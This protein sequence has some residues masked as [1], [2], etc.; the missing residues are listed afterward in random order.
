MSMGDVS[1]A[2]HEAIDE[3]ER[4]SNVWYS[5]PRLFGLEVHLNSGPLRGCSS[6]VFE[7]SAS[8]SPRPIKWI[9]IIMIIIL[10]G[11]LACIPDNLSGGSCF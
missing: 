7:I 6:L 2:T 10:W 4:T 9:G 11:T 5:M 1:S 8:A 3:S